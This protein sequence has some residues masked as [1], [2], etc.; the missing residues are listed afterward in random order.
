MDLPTARILLVDD[1][2]ELCGLMRQYF[3][4][5]RLRLD[6]EHDGHR[7]LATAR[8][9]RHDLVIL[10]VMLPGID[11]FG[12]LRQL[13]QHSHVPVIMLT[14]RTGLADRVAGLDAGADDYLAKPFG[15]EELLARIRAVL[16]RQRQPAVDRA[17]TI[18]A[19]GIR[20]T[21][22][23]RAATCD[24]RPLDLTAIE[25]DILDQ[26]VRSAGRIV[27]RDE[28]IGVL[29]QRDATPFDRST[30]VHVHHLRRKLGARRGVIRTVRGEG[31]LFCVE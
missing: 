14:A 17:R 27:S 6:T 26:L 25:Y 7:G 5:H 15:P 16:R 30:D 13:R 24:G 11:G 19:G 18:E 20:L 1:D 12:V 8:E 21:P 9:H 4:H 3:E 28:L 31:Y 2:E 22:S 23:A 10:D 29:H